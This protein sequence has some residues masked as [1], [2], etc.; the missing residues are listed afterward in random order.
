MSQLSATPELAARLSGL[1]DVWETK[2][3][4]LEAAPRLDSQTASVAQLQQSRRILDNYRRTLA[5]DEARGLGRVPAAELFRALATAEA[6]LA[7]LSQ[8]SAA[9][10]Q[11]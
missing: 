4:E 3:T 2:L 7:Q 11:A 6:S 8:L 9:K 1:L 10:T 5:L